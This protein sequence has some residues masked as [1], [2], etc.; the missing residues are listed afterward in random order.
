M[1]VM[2]FPATVDSALPQDFSGLPS[3]STMQ[4]PHCSRP[5]PNLAPTS[6]RWLR[7]TSSSGV[8]GSAATATSLPFTVREIDIGAP[9]GGWARLYQRRNAGNESMQV[10]ICG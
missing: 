5:Q 9:G 2:L 1:V 8:S 7:N 3:I 10:L 4:Q 6:P